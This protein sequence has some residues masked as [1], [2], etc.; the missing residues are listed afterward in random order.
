MSNNNPLV[1]IGMPVYNG[2]KYVRQALESLLAQDY[3]NFELIIS[4]NASTDGTAQIC[5][6]FAQR[7]HRIR[8]FRNQRN[9]GSA[10]NFNQVVDLSTGKY[11]MWAA[12]DDIYLPGFISRCAGAL[13]ITPSA[14]LAFSTMSALD[15]LGHIDLV[16]DR[17]VETVGLELFRRVRTSILMMGPSLVY[18]LIR[19]TALE[20]SP[21]L[22]EVWG[23]D[24]VLVIR[25]A[26]QGGFCKIAE[27]L[28]VRRRNAPLDPVSIKRILN[29]DW[30][31]PRFYLAHT[32]L[33]WE[34][35]KTVFRSDAEWFMK[36]VLAISSLSC[37]RRIGVCLPLSDFT[38]LFRRIFRKGISLLRPNRPA[39]PSLP[40]KLQ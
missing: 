31:V 27:P 7:D 2:E 17:Y 26:L 29:P 18:S 3:G 11:F 10:W 22:S 40:F 39:S 13:E 23:G 1:S 21:A 16:E 20:G 6:E 24:S 34:V 8:Y 5:Q 4:D 37:S 14:I 30:P 25:L 15:D 19:R 9:M 33:A 35:V 28:Y 38:F 12:H 32:A 36:P